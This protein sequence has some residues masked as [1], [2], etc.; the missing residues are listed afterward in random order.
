MTPDLIASIRSRAELE[1]VRDVLAF[2]HQA[3]VRHG[4]EENQAVKLDIAVEEALV[5][6]IEHAFDPDMIGYFDVILERIPGAIQVTVADKGLPYD[7]KRFDKE[8][9]GLG[10]KLMKG[11]VDEV[12]FLSLGNAGK[13]VEFIKQ[14]PHTNAED[15]LEKE[16]EDLPMVPPETTTTIRLIEPGDSEALARCIYRSYGYSYAMGFIYYPEKTQD[17]LKQ[18][19]L[20]SVVVIG[21][22]NE[23][24]GHL[25]LSLHSADAKVGESGMAVVD[26]R[27]R[28]RGLFKHL[29]NALIDHARESGMYGIY[30]E[31]VAVHPF[32]QKGNLTL[33][34]KETGIIFGLMPPS[35]HFRKIQSEEAK[36]RQSAVLFYLKLHQSPKQTLYPPLHH[37]SMIRKIYERNELDREL[38]DPGQVTFELPEYSVLKTKMMQEALIG[39]ISVEE[40]G[41]DLIP[42]VRHHLHEMAQQKMECVDIDIPLN[43]PAAAKFCASLEMLGF[44]FAGVIPELFG[45]DVLRLQYMNM[46]KIGIDKIVVV[47]EFAKELLQYVTDAYVETYA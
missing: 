36:E 20:R 43:H 29:K 7:F 25:G 27:Y 21:K 10:V 46:A 39:Y 19:L 2:I 38:I 32:T 8:E 33:G 11:L 5:N 23:L 15:Y 31:A 18:G 28:G 14:L 41:E 6:V 26:P 44:F 34:A 16:P 35:M 1:S 13:R 4:L 42:A 12:R 47:S 37:R 40:Y 24:I 22:D 17:L 45:G 9:G 30:S 3:L